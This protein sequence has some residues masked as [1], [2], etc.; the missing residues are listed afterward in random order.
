MGQKFSDRL[1]FMNRHDADADI[2]SYGKDLLWDLPLEFF[3]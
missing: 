2:S 3:P 1:K